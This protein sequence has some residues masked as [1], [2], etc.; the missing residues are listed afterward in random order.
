MEDSEINQLA[1]RL[2][3]KM[4]EPANCDALAQAIAKQMCHFAQEYA[5]DMQR[6][7]ER[8]DSRHY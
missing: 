6:L 1:A 4:M 2:V 3:Q 7:G 5:S 8:L